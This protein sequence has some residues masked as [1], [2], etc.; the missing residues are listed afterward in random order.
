MA[1]C[2]FCIHFDGER[3]KY[4]DEKIDDPYKDVEC[5]AYIDKYLAIAMAEE[6]I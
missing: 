6:L 3:C 5:E 1:K 4:K 2:A